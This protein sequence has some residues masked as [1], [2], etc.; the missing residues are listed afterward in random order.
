MNARRTRPTRRR[1]AA[2]AGAVT[3]AALVGGGVLVA[4]A[5]PALAI[6]ERGDPG[7]GLTWVQTVLI[8]LGIPVAAFV[9]LAML[10]YLPSL[11]RG[12]R[13]RPGRPWTSGS[14]WFGGPADPDAAVGE[15]TSL[16]PSTIEG[17]G[18]SARW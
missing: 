1:I 16:P 17:G 11:V 9:A 13:Y 15:V 12:P 14:V 2:V 5:A 3:T 6:G 7:G 10:V 4:G 18:A 8:Y